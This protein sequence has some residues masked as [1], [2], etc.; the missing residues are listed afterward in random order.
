LRDFIK[1][2]EFRENFKN[3]IGENKYE[4]LIKN[5]EGLELPGDVWNANDEFKNC[6]FQSETTQ[7][8]NVSKFIREFYN[9]KPEKD[10]DLF[11]PED[12]DITFDFVPRMCKKQNCLFCPF[13]FNK[14]L[15]KLSDLCHQQKGKT[16]PILLM[17][18]GYV[19]KC[20]GSCPIQSIHCL[21]Q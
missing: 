21:K 12:F 3:I 20:D 11:A 8:T 4:N 15:S 14:E 1:A 6:F 5:Y 2:A 17:S 7:E 19:Y 18:C 9:D 10:K 13:Y 16:C